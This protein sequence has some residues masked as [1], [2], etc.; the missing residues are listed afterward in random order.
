MI[1]L[2]LL[3]LCCHPL[4]IYS[5]ET[6][7]SIETEVDSIMVNELISTL[8]TRD[9]VEYSPDR[10]KEYLSYFHPVHLNSDNHIDFIYSGFVGA[11]SNGIEIYVN[12]NGS[13]KLIEE[14]LGVIR[15]ITRRFPDSPI[16][17]E[18]IQYGC[19][20]DPGNYWQQWTIAPKN[21]DVTIIKTDKYYFMNETLFPEE[22]NSMVKFKVLNTPYKLRATPEIISGDAFHYHYEQGNLISDYSEGDT[23]YALASST[24]YTGRVW[25]FVAMDRPQNVG[26]HVYVNKSWEKWLGWM[27]SRYLERMN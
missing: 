5:Q 2:S 7:W 24:D 20:D 6:K 21:G 19:C 14:E 15:T 18:F 25:W 26:Y 27:S 1:R 4:L 9:F 11:E 10:L 17:M 3:F 12:K 13:L 8:G 23:G 22:F 16:T